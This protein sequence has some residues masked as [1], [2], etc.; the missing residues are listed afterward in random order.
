VN[1]PSASDLQ[2]YMV[3]PMAF[4]ADL[5]LPVSAKPR[6]GD[7]MT[8]FQRE[9]F[10]ALCPTLLAVAAGNVPPIDRYWIE[11]TKGASK[12]GDIA[13]SLSWL[14]GFSPRPLE[15]RAGASDFDQVNE[16]RKSLRSL[17]RVNDWLL[18]RIAVQT[19]KI[20]NATTESSLDFL[21]S[22]AMGSHGSRPDVTVLNELSHGVDEEFASTLCDDADKLAN[23]VIVMATNSGF[24]GTWQERWRDSIREQAKSD[25]TVYFQKVAEPAPWI[26]PKKLEAAKRR[27]SASR[28]A[29]LWKGIWT[30]GGGDAIDE[31]DIERAL[32]LD[33]PTFSPEPHFLYGA[34]IDLGV[35][36]DRCGFVIV[37]VIPGSGKVKVCN[38][39]S[40][41]PPDGGDIDLRAVRE[42]ILGAHRTYH[43]AKVK[44]DPFQAALL[45]QDLQADGVPMSEMTFS[46][47][48]LDRMARDLLTMFRDKRIELYDDDQLLADLRALSIAERPGGFG[49]KLT[50]PSGPSGHADLGI[51]LACILP[52][53]LATA[54]EQAYQD[55]PDGCVVAY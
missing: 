27:N 1:N 32:V 26:S 40:W 42:T 36:R 48:N 30:V 38:A 13:A 18:G 8:D 25:P 5:T 39:R 16:L 31:Q 7:C 52:V 44:F 19:T 47:Q 29:R 51:A 33:G 23:S 2:R 20:L 24:E 15:M 35:R 54:M 10:E 14:L 9:T 45:S 50:A 17:L 21:T 3:D 12:D 28:Y 41:A 43:F 55:E 49:Y 22:D 11:R 53:A 34:G 6:F 46:G 4:F 37:G